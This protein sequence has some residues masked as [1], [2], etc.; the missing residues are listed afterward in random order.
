[1]GFGGELMLD[2]VSKYFSGEEAEKRRQ[3]VAL[4]TDW[5]AEITRKYTENPDPEYWEGQDPLSYFIADGFFPGYYKQK[6]KA[7]FIAREP[8]PMDDDLDGVQRLLTKG[9]NAQKLFIRR[10]LYIVQGIRE[11]GKLQF[12]SL[13][14]TKDYTK[15]LASENDYGYAFMN[16]SKYANWLDD[17]TK[18]ADYG[19]INQ[20]LEDSNLENRNFFR[21]GIEILD[22]DVIITMNLGK[23]ADTHTLIDQ[24]YLDLC[25]GKI[26]WGKIRPDRDNPVKMTNI[27]F[28]GKS[29][30][31]LNC[32]HFSRPGVS[33]KDF[34]YNP[35]MELIFKEAKH[36]CISM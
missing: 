7:L 33:D 25:F 20:F 17:N 6:T 19:F 3:I 22:P 16:I 10:L 11:G 24:K 29:K 26:E 12:E 30:K 8:L 18:K 5:Q 28:N 13:E 36:G 9:L 31:L 2:S 21:E 1:M 23:K 14:F 4:M 15:E 34:F 27:V 35:I 32:Y